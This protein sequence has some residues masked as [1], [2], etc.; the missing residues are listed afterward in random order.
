MWLLFTV[1]FN[2][3]INFIIACRAE[4]KFYIIRRNK[5]IKITYLCA[6][7][8]QLYYEAVLIYFGRFI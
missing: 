7:N 6:L 8:E 2:F 1:F 3:I 5:M 4:M